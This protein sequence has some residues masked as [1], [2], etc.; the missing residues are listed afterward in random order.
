MPVTIDNVIIFSLGGIAGYLIR[1]LVDHCLAKSRARE[2]REVKRF[3]DAATGFRSKIL[4]E[5]GGIYPIPPVWQPQDYFRFRQS[6]PKVETAAAEFGPFVKHKA[7]L[8]AAVKKYREYCCKVTF[9]GVSVWYA[10]PSMKEPDDIGPVET[11]RKI[12]EHLF[13]FTERK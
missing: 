10:Y 8:D 4:A 7:E 9:E 2:D 11:F 12:V 6:V 5:L 3:D 13:S 1:A